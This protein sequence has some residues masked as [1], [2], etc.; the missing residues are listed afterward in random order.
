MSKSFDATVQIVTARVSNATGYINQKGG[1]EVAE[2]IHEVYN[3]LSS[4]EI[5]EA[6]EADRKPASVVMSD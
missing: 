1:Q 6:H 2:Y 4:I 5:A 3:A